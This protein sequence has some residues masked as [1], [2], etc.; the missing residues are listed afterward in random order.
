MILSR[1]GTADAAALYQ[2]FRG[3][4]PMVEPLLAY[5]GLLENNGED[6]MSIVE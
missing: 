6:I 4:A 2:A 5:R 3:K 1:G